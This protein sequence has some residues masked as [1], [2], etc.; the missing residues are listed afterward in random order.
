MTKLDALLRQCADTI[1]PSRDFV[2]RVSLRIAQ[3]EERKQFFSFLFSVVSLAAM[4]LL[5]SYVVSLFLAELLL[6]ASSDL[7]AGIAE[8]PSLLLSGE[9]WLAFS[10]GALFLDTLF[11]GAAC[12][13]AFVVLQRFLRI[14]HAYSPRFY[15]FI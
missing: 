4:I 6:G 8:D 12:I 14:F 11:L 15:A 7:L 13:L 10:E 2:S 9:S 3:M 5:A 1:T